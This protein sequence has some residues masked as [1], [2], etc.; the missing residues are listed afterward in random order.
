MRARAAVASLW[1]RLGS[2]RSAAQS[3]RERTGL[4][5]RH[6]NARRT[7]FDD[8]GHTTRARGDRGKAAG[9]GL[10]RRHAEGFV[11]GRKGEDVG[12]LKVVSDVLDPP[13]EGH[14]AAK[15]SRLGVLSEFLFDRDHLSGARAHQHQMPGGQI[16]ERRHGREQR[17]EPLALDQPARVRD[18]DPI[19][20]QAQSVSARRPFPGAHRRV[21]RHVDAVRNQMHLARG[22]AGLDCFTRDRLRD[23]DDGARLSEQTVP[24][25]RRGA[26]QRSFEGRRPAAP[27][28]Q[29]AIEFAVQLRS[30][31]EGAGRA[32]DRQPRGQG[33]DTGS[34]IHEHVARDAPAF[35]P[36]ATHPEPSRTSCRDPFPEDPPGEW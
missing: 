20:G 17:L 5:R 32:R 4:A 15:R 34:A 31:H 26:G 27:E 11:Q 33:E 3:F 19:R 29:R 30:K 35:A 8:V 22:K 23:G 16:G 36:G 6:E 14:A 7:V 1:R 24:E 12:G 21:F 10:D 18:Q 28:R 2:V 25:T 13:R 9:L